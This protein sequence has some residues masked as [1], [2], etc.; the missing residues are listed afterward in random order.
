MRKRFER[1]NGILH[2]TGHLL[3]VLGVV[4]LLPMVVAALHW[5]QRG[6]GR[7]TVN[8][9]V[10][11]AAFSFVVGFILKNIYRSETLD[12]VSSMLM[13]AVGWLACSAVGAMPF[14]IGIRSGYLNAY[15]E[16][17]SGFTTTGITVHT[18]LDT[19]PYSILFW[20]ALTQWFGGLGI[21][22]FFLIVTFR[23][24][25]AHHILGAESHK[26]SSTR[27]APGLFNTL[28]ILWL[29]YG[30]FTLLAV[31]ILVALKMP[32][33]D[34]VC[35]A[36]TALS[37]GGFSPHDVSIDFYH[38]SGHANYRLIEYALT[39]I[40]M[41]GGVNFLI[42]YRVLTGDIKALWDNI[43]IRYWWRLIAAFT[44]IVMIDHFRQ[45]GA[46]QALLRSETPITAAEAERTFRVGLFQ[47]MSILTTT[48]FGTQDIGS[49]FFGAASKQLFLVMMVI[50]GCVGS[51][52]GGFKVLRVAMLNRLLW[53]ELFKAKVSPR[54]ATGLVIDKKIVPDV[55]I[56]RVVALFFGW[57]ALLVTGGLITAL[58]SEHGTLESFS[59]MFS[60]LGNIGPCYLSVQEMIDLHPV[61]KI[62]YI[63][64][65]LAGRLELLPVLLLFS[66]RAWR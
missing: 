28:K 37:T 64:G 31:G 59:G 62:T 38:Q 17:M 2:Y 45:T 33:F 7:M 39:F 22:S 47:V 29:I 44:A 48:G 61:V 66:P 21:L 34:A 40:M 46:W 16:A 51:T 30:G 60:A 58:F 49:E 14:V 52:G 3:E 4:L 18:G 42:H 36:F 25:S 13:C 20:R 35:H 56:H 1:L 5:H 53:G 15:F 12:T 57:V 11:P 43:E 9:F 63:M 27:P 19:M 6:D 50:G 54:A 23:A 8:A 32:V 41:L 65:M 24:S 55:E 26:I 10:F